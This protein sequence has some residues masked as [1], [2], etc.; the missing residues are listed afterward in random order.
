MTKTRNKNC[1]CCQKSILKT[2][3][4][5]LG[6]KKNKKVGNYDTI[7][8]FVDELGR[9]LDKVLA[10]NDIDKYEKILK[11]YQDQAIA[12]GL[13]SS[14][15]EGILHPHYDR[16]KLWRGVEKMAENLHHGALGDLVS[17][18]QDKTDATSNSFKQL[19]KLLK[20]EYPL[21]T[22]IILRKINKD[23]KKFC[24]QQK[25][26]VEKIEKKLTASQEGKYEISMKELENF[27]SILQGIS[28]EIVPKR[29]EVLQRIE[30]MMAE[31]KVWGGGAVFYL[32]TVLFFLE[33]MTFHY[34]FRK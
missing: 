26:L 23:L 32:L 13:D 30:K 16:L 33:T 3:L 5:K 8:T 22:S 9:E 12:F 27:K 21:L 18:T 25:A 31:V 11:N 4:Q 20:I 34:V 1:C 14:V 2:L 6:F 15:Y 29:D 19:Y 24:D 7:S 28:S 17:S 10:S